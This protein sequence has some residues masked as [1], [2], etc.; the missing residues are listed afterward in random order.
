M[1][2]AFTGMVRP[3]LS[4]A[5]LVWSHEIK[6]ET[7]KSKIDGLDRLAL[8]ACAQVKPS[9]PTEGLRVIYDLLP[10]TIFLEKTAIA[11]YKRHLDILSNNWRG[12]AKTNTYSISHLMHW[13]NT[14]EGSRVCVGETDA[15][16][17]T[18]WERNFLVDTASFDSTVAP[19]LEGHAIY[20]DDSL[21]E[22]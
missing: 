2:W 18:I 19:R 12:S 20:T 9:T 5:S 10:S 11:T 7:I 13:Q 1:K 22:D 14:V 16:K 3:I 6:T 15:T 4:Y 8:L 17:K 21:L